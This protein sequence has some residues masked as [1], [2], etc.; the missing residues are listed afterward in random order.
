VI[1]DMGIAIEM[2]D[3]CKTFKSSGADI[4]RRFSLKV[5]TGQILAIVG[6][7]GS[8]KST[9]LN[10]CALIEQTQGGDVLIRGEKRT[11][12][13]VGTLPLAYIFQRDALLPWRSVLDNILVG[14][15]CRSMITPE[16]KEKALDYLARFG[17]QGYEEAFPNTLSGG[18]RQRVAIIQNLLIDPH[19]L[20]MDE[21]FASLDFQTKLILEEE[22]LR[23]IRNGGNGQ[24]PRTVI[25]VTHDIEE[26][27]LLADRV[28]VLGRH[29]REPAHIALDMQVSLNPEDRDPAKA[30]ESRVV[31]ESFQQIWY[32]IK[33]YVLK[34]RV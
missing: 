4:F 22:L 5:P 25:L 29:H 31:R 18:Q 2:R 23:V 32:A 21:P 24:K 6:P 11:T 1:K 26:A 13:E 28:I 19:I 34:S 10:I 33:P 9:L 3:I 14:A 17:L 30:R 12:A 20:L 15:R 7:S 8:G 16:L 27:L